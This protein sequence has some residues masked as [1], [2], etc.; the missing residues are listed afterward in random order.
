[1]KRRRKSGSKSSRRSSKEENSLVT[2]IKTDNGTQIFFDYLVEI[3]LSEK[4]VEEARRRLAT[5]QDLSTRQLFRLLDKHENGRFTFED[6]RN[7]MNEIGINYSDTRSIV[8]LYSSFDTNEKCVLRYEDLVKMIT[9]YDIGYANMLYKDLDFDGEDISDENFELLKDC[10]NKLFNSK[11]VAREAK[12]Y[13]KDSD[14]NFKRIFSCLDYGNKGFL[15]REDFEDFLNKFDGGYHQSDN[16]EIG[17]FVDKC[18]LD[19]DGNVSYKDFYMFFS[20]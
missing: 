13:F 1:M 2:P 17:I 8:D 5:R 20:L 11:R 9:P 12:K 10:F 15:V 14:I 7:F 4:A 16:E 18:D 6:F 3:I 19:N